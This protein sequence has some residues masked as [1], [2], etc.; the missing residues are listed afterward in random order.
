M[1]ASRR[2]LSR[3]V[4]SEPARLLMT[5]RDVVAGRM[6][7]SELGVVIGSSV[8]SRSIIFAIR[9]RLSV[10]LGGSINPYRD[11]VEDAANEALHRVEEAAQVTDGLG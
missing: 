6:I 3:V 10:M 5:T 2:L 8:R 4:T 1:L 9:A 11:L 7:T